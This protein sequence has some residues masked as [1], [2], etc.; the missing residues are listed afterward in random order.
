M[1][2]EVKLISKSNV[3]SPHNNSSEGETF[4]D[5]NSPTKS[6]IPVHL[7]TEKVNEKEDLL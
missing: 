6:G 1:D 7:K 4:R 2:T 3:M 5:D